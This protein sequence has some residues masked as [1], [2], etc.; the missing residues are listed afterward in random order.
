MIIY[1][2]LLKNLLEKKFSFC[3]LK[4]CSCKK[5]IERKMSLS[6]RLSMAVIYP[7]VNEL[8]LMTN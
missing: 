4:F 2:F 8:D 1:D 5:C 6:D 7:Y 3:V